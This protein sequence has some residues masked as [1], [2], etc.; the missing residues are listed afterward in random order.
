MKAAQLCF[1]ANKAW[2]PSFKIPGSPTNLASLNE[3]ILLVRL[4]YTFQMLLDWMAQIMIMLQI[5]ITDKLS[6][7]LG[8]GMGSV[9][10]LVE[11]QYDMP[12]WILNSSITR[13]NILQQDFDVV[14]PVRAGL[15]MVESQSVEQLM[16]DG[17]VIKAST[18]GQGHHLFTA[19]TA[20]IGVAA[21]Q[22]QRWIKRHWRLRK[23]FY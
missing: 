18:A 3:T 2:P 5:K 21:G 4:F 11:K 23:A 22:D 8:V 17:A 20:N 7:L 6:C 10:V 15:L 19:T 16:L 14:V 9:G 13:H 1:K 12:F